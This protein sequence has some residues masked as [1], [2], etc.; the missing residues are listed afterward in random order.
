MLF[1]YNGS[2]NP[3]RNVAVSYPLVVQYF[4]SFQKYSETIIVMQ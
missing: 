2:L 3:A 4:G 1:I